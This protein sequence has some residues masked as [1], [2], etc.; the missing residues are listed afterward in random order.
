M[1]TGSFGGQTDIRILRLMIVDVRIMELRNVV[2]QDDDGAVMEHEP[3][4]SN[5]RNMQT[6]WSQIWGIEIVSQDDDADGAISTG[7]QN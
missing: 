7:S 5:T 2:R 3:I 4:N 1:L 6:T